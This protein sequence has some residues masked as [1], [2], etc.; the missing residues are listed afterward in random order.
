[1]SWQYI[2]RVN[3]PTEHS[4]SG[5]G[6]KTL[7]TEMSVCEGGGTKRNN[8]RKSCRK[9]PLLYFY[10]KAKRSS[11]RKQYVKDKNLMNSKD[12]FKMIVTVPAKHNKLG[13]EMLKKYYN[14]YFFFPF[15]RLLEINTIVYLSMIL[16]DVGMNCG[17]W[18]RWRKRR[19]WMAFHW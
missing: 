8:L 5:V 7:L 10:W 19:I 13:F 14:K 3:A 4:L 11:L 12:M 2:A 6:E 15:L 1:M 17:K 18:R 16:K 9:D